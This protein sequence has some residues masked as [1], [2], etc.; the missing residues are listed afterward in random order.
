[1][2]LR[3][4]HTYSILNVSQ[5]TFDEIKN[6]LLAAGYGDMIRDDGNGSVIDMHG[7]ALKVGLDDPDESTP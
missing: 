4:T 7:I 5:T 3:Q 2:T 6:I 1:M